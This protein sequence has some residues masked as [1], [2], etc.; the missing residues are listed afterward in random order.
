[1]TPLTRLAT[2]T[3]YATDDPSSTLRPAAT[4]GHTTAHGTKPEGNPVNLF[5]ASRLP[6]SSWPLTSAIYGSAPLRAG[7]A[8]AKLSGVS[9][10][11]L[12]PHNDHRRRHFVQFRGSLPARI[13]SF[14]FSIISRLTIMCWSTSPIAWLASSNNIIFFI[15]RAHLNLFIYCEINFVRFLNSWSICWYILFVWFCDVLRLLI[16]SRLLVIFMVT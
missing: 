15:S 9:S 16:N 3:R 7:Q 10:L 1:M 8:I 12:P 13:P 14:S 5:R 6:S 2:S 4:G 11:A